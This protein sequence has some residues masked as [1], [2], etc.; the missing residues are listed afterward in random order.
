M[1]QTALKHVLG[2]QHIRQRALTFNNDDAEAL[3]SASEPSLDALAEFERV[4]DEVLV[5]D[6]DSAG[7]GDANWE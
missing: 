2:P 7:R 1:D 3:G 5:R 4:L 6:G